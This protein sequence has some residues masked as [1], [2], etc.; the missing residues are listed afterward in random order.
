MGGGKWR[1]RLQGAASRRC[2]DLG[3]KM[4]IFHL[5][6][7]D[8][9]AIGAAAFNRDARD[10]APL[11]IGFLPGINEVS[12]PPS[13]RKK[14]HGI[15]STSRQFPGDFSF[16]LSR[17]SSVLCKIPEV[18]LPSFK[19]FFFFFLPQ[20]RC[21]MWGLGWKRWKLGRKNPLFRRF[22]VLGFNPRILGKLEIFFPP[23]K[24]IKKPQNRRILILF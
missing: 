10:K 6:L 20:E 12:L 16:P 22:R 2:F 21:G 7:R 5:K 17:F 24:P 4:G 8:F 3:G 13:A 15:F 19:K 14:N 23:L 11:E 18:H 1:W 9:G